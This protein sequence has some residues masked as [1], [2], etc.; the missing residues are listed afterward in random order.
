MSEKTYELGQ[1]IFIL[2]QEYHRKLG[3][4][5][6]KLSKHT[7]TEKIVRNKVTFTQDTTKSHVE[8]TY[9][10][11]NGHLFSTDPDAFEIIKVR[12]GNF[13]SKEEG[14]AE[15]NKMVSKE[16]DEITET[17]DMLVKQLEFL[18]KLIIK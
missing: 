8:T 2:D 16:I 15:F 4:H 12:E 18:K 14:K 7:V 5:Y 6:P 17:Y 13:L 3:F 11:S 1:E 9:R 10:L